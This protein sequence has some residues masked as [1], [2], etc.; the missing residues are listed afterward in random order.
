[1]IILAFDCS[2]LMSIALMKNGKIIDEKYFPQ[3]SSHSEK[4]VSELKNI[5]NSHNLTFKEVDLFVANNGPGGYTG[6]RVALAVLKMLKISFDKPCLTL[7]SFEILSYKYRHQKA[8]LQVAISGNINEIFFSKYRFINNDF[9]EEA[10]QLLTDYQT[11]NQQL[12]I[13]DF[14]CGSANKLFIEHQNKSNEDDNNMV[15]E[16]TNLALKIFKNQ[17]QRCNQEILPLYLREPK[18]TAKK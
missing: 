8:N 10:P 16:M 14:I 13:D 6:I 7:N 18:I 3:N 5:I 12:N 17:P 1:M 9:I 2:S 4:L 15:C 11:I